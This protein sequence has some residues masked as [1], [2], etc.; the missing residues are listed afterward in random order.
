MSLELFPTRLKK[1]Q[2][3][4]YI[5]C[6]LCGQEVDEERTEDGICQ[7]CLKKGEIYHCSR[8]GKELVYTNYQKYIKKR[9][10]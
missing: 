1:N 2:N 3:A 4:T 5:R 10:K 7:E 6:K 8:C 9:P